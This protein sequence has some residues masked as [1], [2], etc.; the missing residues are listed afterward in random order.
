MSKPLFYVSAGSNLGDRAANIAAAAD[1]LRAVPGIRVAAVSGA[2][3]T[4]PVDVPAK[5]AD[6]KFLNAAFA[7]ETDMPAHA[8]L[9]VL[10]SVEKSLGRVRP[11]ARNSPRTVDLDITCAFAP[12]GTPVTVC[13]PPVLEIPHPRAASRDF[14]LAPLAEIAPSAAAWLRGRKAARAR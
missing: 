7:L 6:M 5:F 11:A 12:D 10:Q 2:I 1:A 8:L 14:V 4:E 3:E 13:D 9:A